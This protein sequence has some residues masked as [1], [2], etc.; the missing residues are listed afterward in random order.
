M[1]EGQEKTI[2][3]LIENG[4]NI[5]AVNVDNDTALIFALDKGMHQIDIKLFCGK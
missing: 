4:A 2:K 3:L 1:F 5:N